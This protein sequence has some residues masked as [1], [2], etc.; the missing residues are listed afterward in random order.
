MIDRYKR[1]NC[2]RLKVTIKDADGALH[3]PST[4]VKVTLTNAG[5][6]Y[7]TAQDMTK[8]ST[9]VYYY[10]WQTDETDAVG[11]YNMK[12]V[13]VDSSKTVVTE[14]NCAFDLFN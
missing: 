13:S 7:L 6:E 1:G 12:V 10:D 11:V 9:G 8:A 5:V 2:I 4:S 3:D 14:D